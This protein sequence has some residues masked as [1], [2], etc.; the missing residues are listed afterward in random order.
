MSLGQYPGNWTRHPSSPM[1]SLRPGRFDSNHIHAPMVV[2]EGGRYRMWYSGS[3]RDGNEFHRIGYAESKDGVSWE[4]LDEP[5]LSPSDPEGYFSVP[6]V[7]RDAGGEVLRQDGRLMMWITGH[8]RMCDLRLCTSED[9]ISWRVETPE[10]IS[11]E[12]YS[13]TVIHED[14]VYKMWY[15]Y[16]TGD[17]AMAIFYATSGDGLDWAY[18]GPVMRSVE[19]WEHK[20]VLYPYVLKRDGVYEM[21]YTSYGDVCDLAVAFSE[22]GTHWEKTAGPILTPD[23][24]SSWDSVYCSNA[25][26]LIE[27]DGRDKM[28]YASRIDMYHKY[29]AIGLAVKEGR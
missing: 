14:G 1:L 18:H 27:P 7:L 26:V 28:Y 12:V 21:Y 8:N 9:G 6:A 22:D 15:T 19:P 3:D 16:L 20:N 23:P 11:T 24:D 10:P 5:V 2:R 4:R 13:P 29:F 17:G 25:S